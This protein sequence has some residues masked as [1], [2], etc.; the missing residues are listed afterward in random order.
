M[1]MPLQLDTVVGFCGE[2]DDFILFKHLGQV[3]VVPLTTPI[4]KARD[5]VQALRASLPD[6]AHTHTHTHTHTHK[7]HEDETKQRDMPSRGVVSIDLS[8]RGPGTWEVRILQH[9]KKV[10]ALLSGCG[11]FGLRRFGSDL[12]K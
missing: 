4:L 2:V 7:D 10:T 5:L 8:S 12:V 1:E 11:G 9:G 6:T 3:F